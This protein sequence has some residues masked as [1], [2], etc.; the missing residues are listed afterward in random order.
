MIT[1]YDRLQPTDEREDHP[2]KVLDIAPLIMV[3]LPTV[4]S[5]FS[6]GGASFEVVDLPPE[7]LL[8]S[9]S[10]ACGWPPGVNGSPFV[11]WRRPGF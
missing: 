8:L 9:L 2:I 4:S 7:I 1:S 11:E 10:L 3:S 5:F 6:R